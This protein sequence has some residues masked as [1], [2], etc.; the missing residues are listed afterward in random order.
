MKILLIAPAPVPWQVGGAE[1][2]WRALATALDAHATAHGGRCDWIRLPSPERT[3]QEVLSSYRAFSQF[4]ASDYDVVI[5]SK[6][7]AW[8]V[9]H[10]RHIIYLQH[11]LR[12][13]YDTYP[14]RCVPYPQGEP[15][16]GLQDF[17]K[18]QSGWGAVD[19]LWSRLETI[20]QD[21]EHATQLYQFPGP[22]MRA[23]VHWLDRQALNAAVG[24][25]AISQRVRSRSEYFEKPDRV[26][27]FYHDS[28]VVDQEVLPSHVTHR[29]YFFACGRM[30]PAKRFD[31]TLAAYLAA[32]PDSGPGLYLAGDGPERARLMIQSAHRADVHWLGR[33]SEA[34]LKA[35]YQQAAAVLFVPADEDWGLAGLE[36]LRLG[37]PVITT[38]DAGGIVEAMQEGVNGFICEPTPAA[39]GRAIHQ[40]MAWRSQESFDSTGI[41]PAVPLQSWDQLVESLLHLLPGN[42]SPSPKILE[43]PM[44]CQGVKPRIVVANTFAS[45]PVRSG[46]QQRV[47]HLY[48]QLGA[49]ADVDLISLSGFASP[50][51]EVMI[52]PGVRE[53]IYPR[54]RYMALRESEMAQRA[55]ASCGDVMVMLHP[56][57]TGDWLEHLTAVVR[58]AD[59]VVS[60]H[61]YVAPALRIAGAKDLVYESHNVESLLKKN[62]LRAVPDWVQAVKMEE[63]GLCHTARLVTVCGEDD[64]RLMQVEH[65][66]QRLPMILPNGV[67]PQT[68]PFMPWHVRK[69]KPGFER[70]ALFMGSGHAPNI[71]SA[72]HVLQLAVQLPQ[73]KFFIMGSV[74]GALHK[75]VIPANVRLLGVVSEAERLTW[76]SCVWVGLNPMWEGSG[77]NLKIV[78]YAA[79]GVPIISSAFGA[80]GNY[81]MADIHYEVVADLPDLPMALERLV[82][83][84]DETIHQRTIA[85]RQLVEGELSW[86]A[87]AQAFARHL[88]LC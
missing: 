4:D 20:A 56:E 69:S 67:D 47:H 58:R 57:L 88:P 27:V 79:A 2:L 44:I 37:I 12:G 65:D 73:W 17:F 59:V 83:C 42:V 9:R 21:P 30:E 8:M 33:I 7:P 13:L 87:I 45:V 24:L 50:A 16:D 18:T 72:K 3:G 54:T 85:A 74:C 52:A 76:L 22:V 26:S 38:T 14:A 35:Y 49:W 28:D 78:D 6:Y 64:A 41:Q 31:L 71:R 84:T 15:W 51:R 29:D 53:F 25:A 48:K 10:P 19:I 23:V 63:R 82:S 1:I 68:V 43:A 32:Y 40:V 80:R 66:L 5:S 70:S 55:H 34:E 81:F 75:E 62:I 77:T 86:R 61:V 36:P 46:G 11:T 39:L 60:S